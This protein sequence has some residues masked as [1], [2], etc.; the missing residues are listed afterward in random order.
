M[1][2]EAR[3]HLRAAKAAYNGVRRH[4]IRGRGETTLAYETARSAFLTAL[5]ALRAEGVPQQEIADRIKVTRGAVAN[6]YRQCRPT[7]S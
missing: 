5:V 3:A 7:G 1:T 4:G 6:G 2:P